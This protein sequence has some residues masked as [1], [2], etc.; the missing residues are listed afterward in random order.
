MHWTRGVVTRLGLA[1]NEA[2]TSIGQARQESFHFLGY[3]FGLHRNRKNGH[4][5][6][7]ARLPSCLLRPL[8]RLSQQLA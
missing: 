6:L 1:L 8:E 4:R 3:P 7:G 5:Y 2:K